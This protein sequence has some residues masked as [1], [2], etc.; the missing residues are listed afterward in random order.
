M[1]GV[2][3]GPLVLF[4]GLDQYFFIDVPIGTE[5]LEADLDNGD[6]EKVNDEIRTISY[7]VNI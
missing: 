2:S 3:Y 5:R 7:M 4:E 6:G 1:D